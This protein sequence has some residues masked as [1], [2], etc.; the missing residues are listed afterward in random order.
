MDKILVVGSV[1]YDI[2][3]SVH[4]KIRDEI[5]IKDGKLG[6]LNMMFTAANKKQY[7][8][9]TAGNISYGLGLLG[10]HPVLF[11]VAGR[12]FTHDYKKHLEDK[13]V[14][15]RV[16]EDQKNWTATFYGVSDEMQEQL[17]IWQPNV[18]GDLMPTTPLTSTIS[19]EELKKVKVAIFSAGTGVSILNH[20]KQLRDICGNSVKII[21]DPS[22]VISIFY[23]KE[24]LV[25]SLKL[26]DI[27]IGN[28]V[29]VEQMKTLLGLDIKEALS[30]GL[31]YVVETKGK[32]GSVIH[33]K[34]DKKVV[35][36]V[37]VEN[38][39]ESTGAGDAY[40]AGFLYGLQ[41]DHSIEECCRIG[42]ILGAKCVQSFSG[43]LYN[44]SIVDL[45]TLDTEC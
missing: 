38:V 42:S 20:M 15:V 13:G 6:P 43:Q 31:E 1:A 7:Y 39:V 28:E 17:G 27:F 19:E 12:E 5:L 10:S 33:T 41:K 25:E 44:I 9:G 14:A 29:E 23:D 2:I 24:L 3:F 26:A 40:R 21:F 11:S 16:Y 22:Q 36:A 30:L 35:E 18:H 37:G 45:K 4:G 32:D 8:G 34:N